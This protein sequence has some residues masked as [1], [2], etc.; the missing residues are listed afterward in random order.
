MKR[1]GSFRL[2]VWALLSI[3]FLGC[4]V[5]SAASLKGKVKNHVYYSPANNFTVPVPAGS[6]FQKWMTVDDDFKKDHATGDLPVGSVSFHDDFGA[7]IGIQYAMVPDQYMVKLQSSDTQEEAMKAWLHQ[8]VM[9]MLYLPAFPKSQ[10][11]Q[12][13]VGTFEEMPALLAM[14]VI[15]EASGMVAFQQGT[16]K[17]MDSRR[18]IVI[19]PR[20]KFVYLLFTE[21]LT[22]LSLG[23]GKADLESAGDWQ[24]FTG[25]LKTFYRSIVFQEAAAQQA[26]PRPL[27][28]KFE[29]NVYTSP[30]GDFQVTAGGTF[31]PDAVVSDG[32]TNKGLLSSWMYAASPSGTGFMVESFPSPEMELDE[33]LLLFPSVRDK[34][35]LQ[36]SRGREWRV[37]SDPRPPFSSSL[38]S[39]SPGGRPAALVLVSALFA[40]R[41]RIYRVSAAALPGTSQDELITSGG[42]VLDGVLSSFL[43]LDAATT[44]QAPEVEVKTSIKGAFSDEVYTDPAHDFRVRAPRMARQTLR[45]QDEWIPNGGQV[46]FGDPLG[47]FYRVVRVDI[48]GMTPEDALHTLQ[49]PWERQEL[50][51]ARGRELR[52]LDVERANA[53]VSLPTLSGKEVKQERPDLVTAN[54]IFIANDRVHHVVAGVVS[55][56]SS[57]LQNAAE[58]ARQRL[59]KF[60]SGFEATAK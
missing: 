52:V 55:F 4:G 5:T 17:R 44:E 39:A 41:G 28:G 58:A 48:S 10:I 54:A 45:I 43:A 20:G 11:T 2:P 35:V 42:R 49:E 9:P 36:T 53:E 21:T 7:L 18:G 23:Q 30:E 29:H 24:D 12:E 1:L 34:R 60:L 46:M 57:N 19:F 47:G 22:A 26:A 50:Q 16:Q 33:A 25:G 56:D 3:L 38:E 6:M 37:V 31:P 51:T 13:A 59:E 15:P 27:R 8:V 14:V 40:A 32:I